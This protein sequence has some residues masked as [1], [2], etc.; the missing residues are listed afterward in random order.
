M[1][2]IERSNVKLGCL[3]R[4]WND[5]P[6]REIDLNLIYEYNSNSLCEEVSENQKN[7]NTE[8]I[9]AINILESFEQ[10]VDSTPLE[11]LDKKASEIDSPSKIVPYLTECEVSNKTL[12]SKFNNSVDDLFADCD[13]EEC[14]IFT[15]D[16]E[17]GFQ[18]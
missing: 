6:G 18:F 7:L 4:N 11:S 16:E 12:N 2:S 3:L 10:S 17:G 14:E 15:S 8:T 5:I 13:I 9:A 1:E